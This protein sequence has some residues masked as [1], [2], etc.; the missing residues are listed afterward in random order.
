LEYFSIC[1]H[2]LFYVVFMAVRPE[3][4]NHQWRKIPS[5]EL[6]IELE[7][8]EQLGWATGRAGAS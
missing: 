8:D 6:S 4:A 5:R 2:S 3:G 1:L 7:A